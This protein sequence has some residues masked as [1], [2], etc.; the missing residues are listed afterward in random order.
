MKSPD[1]RYYIEVQNSHGRVKGHVKT[2]DVISTLFVYGCI[3]RLV[4]M[5]FIAAYSKYL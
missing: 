5:N 4:S 3:R 2:N 1:S